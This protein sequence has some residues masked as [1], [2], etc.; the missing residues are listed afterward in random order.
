[1]T[2]R[3]LLVHATIK[4][5]NKSTSP[6]LDAQVLLCYVLKKP[7]EYLFME[8]E[9]WIMNQTAKKFLKLVAFRK[10]GWPVA[11]LTGKKEFFGLNFFVNKNVLIPRP[12]TETLVELILEYSQNVRPHKSGVSRALKILDIGTGSGCIIISLAKHL[13]NL[14]PTTYNL[15]YA[16]DVSKKALAVAKRNARHHK[17]RITFKRG[18]LLEPWKN[19]RFDIIVA[20]LPYLPRVEDPSTKFE[21]KKALVAKKQGL[22]LIEKLFDQ[23]RKSVPIRTSVKY[24][25]LEIDPRQATKIKNLARRY[26]PGYKTKIYKDLSGKN[27]FATLTHPKL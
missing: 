9:S 8:H 6:A 19:R 13:Y 5:R 10:K 15:F 11:Y 25:F 7:K 4:L 27:R 20:N 14:S 23:I 2:I 18:D 1:M 12:E 22:E 3:E 26:L 24:I 17:V 21:P 16:S